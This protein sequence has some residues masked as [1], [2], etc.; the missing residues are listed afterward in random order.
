MPIGALST[1]SLVIDDLYK[2]LAKQNAVNKNTTHILDCGIGYGIYGPMIRQWIDQ[3]YV[4]R[5]NTYIMGIEGFSGYRNPSWQAYNLVHEMT[6]EKY[7][8]WP[9]A[10]NDTF[11]AI[12]ILDVIEHFEANVGQEV[13]KELKRRLKPGGVLYVATP[14]IMNPQGSVYGNDLEKHIHEWKSEDFEK[15]NFSIIT[16]G[17]EP[18]F[19]GN[20]MILAKYNKPKSKF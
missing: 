5:F 13:I 15:L 9:V 7:L 17:K 18:D 8:G 20:Y 12:L 16:N 10:Y 19:L 14:G 2:E 1:S 11:N 3:G 4:E 6:I